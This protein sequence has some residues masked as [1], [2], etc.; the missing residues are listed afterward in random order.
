MD[1]NRQ[2]NE[3]PFTIRHSSPANADAPIGIFDSGV[4]GLT[5]FRALE[6]R[7]PNESL[8]YLGDT[9]RIPYGTRSKETIERYAL[10]D[11]AFIQAKN[12]KAIVIACN[13]VSSVAAHRLREAC[14]VPVLG[15]IG[16][17]SRRAVQQ[18]RNGR[19]GVIGTEATIASGAY[20]K[21]M[22]SLR[23][24]LKIISRACPLLV[25]LAEEGWMEH[26]VTRQVA[27]EY[28]ED[29]R[30]TE[31]DTLVLGCTHYPI[32]KNVI[33]QVMG[34]AVSLIDSGE[35][36]AD[37]VAERLCA[38]GLM[39]QS[40]APRSEQFYVTDSARRFRKVAEYFLGRPIESLETIELGQL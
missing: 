17:G 16:P 21:A 10:E 14:E 36:V 26:P 32:L 9:A 35:A 1:F 34:D 7:L 20:E 28:L 38:E 39:R 15:V 19:V 18:S 33:Q 22:M 40:A 25:P 3:P 13:T 8:I 2:E 27:T 6:K 5:V 24:G 12:V 37:V 31:I 23:D 4:G 11:A 30:H 29:F